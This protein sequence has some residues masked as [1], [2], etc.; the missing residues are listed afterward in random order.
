MRVWLDVD[1]CNWLSLDLSFVYTWYCRSL[2][3][4]QL[5][6]DSSVVRVFARQVW[7]HGFAHYFGQ[8]PVY[9]FTVFSYATVYITL[10]RC[11]IL[12][13]TFQFCQFHHLSRISGFHKFR[14]SQVWW[15][16]MGYK[17]SSISWIYSVVLHWSHSIAFKEIVA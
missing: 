5:S 11:I 9:I 2:S 14:F 3:P 8:L 16:I 4:S 13:C 1:H 7:G 17:I 10:C 6:P 15:I 12:P